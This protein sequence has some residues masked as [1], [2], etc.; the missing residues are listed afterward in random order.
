M[1]GYRFG[2]AAPKEESTARL[3]APDAFKPIDVVTA[4]AS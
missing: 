2:K 1:Q 3:C 4:Q